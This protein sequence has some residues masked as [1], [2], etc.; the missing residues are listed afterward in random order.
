MD[1]IK[2]IN[3]RNRE[4]EQ[5]EM[6]VESIK[7]LGLMKPIRVNDKFLERT[8]IY[9]LICGQGRLQAHIE[10]GRKT[11]VA[12]VITCTRKEALLQSLVEN[13]ART[14]HETMAF[15]REL[16]K[17]HDEGLTMDRI[18]QIACKAKSYITE[19]IRLVEQGEERLI[20]GVEQGVFPMSF[21]ADVAAS[22]GD[23]QHLLM[24]AFDEGLVSTVNFAQAKRL[25]LDRAARKKDSSKEAPP[26]SVQELKRDI[27]SVT[28]LRE[29]YVREAKSKEG[30]FLTLLTC[31]NTLWRDAAFVDV[32]RQENLHIRPDLAGKFQYDSPQPGA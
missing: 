14:R 26:Y 6:N 24:D 25:I 18:A 1:K 28:E 17:M 5:F 32:L 11:V 10:M 3:H 9:E 15:A 12:E 31:L 30:Q 7:N 19:L 2:V 22:N 8:G 29:S 23:V 21:A 20:Q 4:R 13:I 16:K 27:A